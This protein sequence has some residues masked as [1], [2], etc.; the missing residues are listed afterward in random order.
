MSEPGGGAPPLVVRRS[1]GSFHVLNVDLE[2]LTDV[3]SVAL[4]VQVWPQI[5]DLAAAAGEYRPR[6]PTVGSRNAIG[7]TELIDTWAAQATGAARSSVNRIRPRLLKR[8]DVIEQVMDG[9]LTTLDDVARELGMTLT[10]TLAEGAKSKV[11]RTKSD[12]G[13][14]DKFLYAIEPILQY[15][16]VWEK[17]EYRYP[18]VNPKEAQKRLKKIAEAMEHL[19]KIKEDLE[20]RSHVATLSSPSEKRRR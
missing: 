3:Q 20:P 14:S 5:R 8:P 4:A 2:T 10:V 1:D 19:T 7:S 18:H 13:R 16:R 9:R 12:F 17:K 15:A 11:R 6:D